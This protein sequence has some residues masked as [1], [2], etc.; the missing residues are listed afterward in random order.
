MKSEEIKSFDRRRIELI[1]TISEKWSHIEDF[2]SVV[3]MVTFRMDIVI[4]GPPGSGKTTFI[5]EVVK[6]QGIIPHRVTLKSLFF[7]FNFLVK[8]QLY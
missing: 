5:E 6:I 3:N 1:N 8:G 4:C 2:E 7:N